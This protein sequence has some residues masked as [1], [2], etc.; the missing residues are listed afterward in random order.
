MVYVLKDRHGNERPISRATRLTLVSKDGKR[1]ASPGT[2]LS[3]SWTDK[4][5][6]AYGVYP[7]TP[8]PKPPT[9]EP[10][11]PIEDTLTKEQRVQKMLDKFGL[12]LAEFKEVVGL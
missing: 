1:Q 9:A 5:R 2:I 4:D 6:A 11:V 8:K 10:P 12:T 7:A 3:E